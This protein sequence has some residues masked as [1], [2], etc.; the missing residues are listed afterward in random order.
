M[1]DTD[2]DL[3]IVGGG[4]AGITLA[5][6][7]E[8][9]GLRIALLESGGQD[10]DEATQDLNEGTLLGNSVYE[11]SGSRL[12][13]L[14]GTSNHWGG[15]CTPLDRIDFDRGPPGF[16]GWPMG[17]DEMVPYW[18]RAHRYCEVGAYTYDPRALGPS[19]PDHWLF[20]EGDGLDTVVLRQ[21]TPT[22]WGEA[23]GDRLAASGSIHVWLWTNA[24]G[25]STIPGR[26]RET[27]ATATLDGVMRTF[28][29]RAVVLAAGAIEGTRLLMWSNAG[30]GTQAGDSGGL[31]GRCYMDHIAGG[32]GFLHFER[33][34]SDKVYWAPPDAYSDGGT[35][36]FFA[37]RL[38]EA[39]LMETG[40]PNAIYHLL[41]LSTDA[42][43]RR[44]AM[45]ADQAFSSVRDLVKFAIGRDVGARFDPGTA[46]CAAVRN[47][48]E[49]VVDRADRLIN[50]QGV[51]SALLRFEAEERPGRQSHI[52]L[53][54]TARDALG[55]PR[56]VL[57]WSPATDDIEAVRRGAVEIGRMAG[58]LGL[59]RVELEDKSGEEYGVGTAWHQLG[60][61][62]MA[63]SPTAGV[64]DA[65]GRIHGAGELYVASGALFPTGGR[66]NPTLTITALSLRLADYLTERLAA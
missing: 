40:L 37:L 9:T 2:Y 7:L 28:S 61:M 39:A 21:S 24:T 27:V 11:L 34:Q 18:R 23:Y 8:A 49:F 20:D 36:L 31:L 42:E 1:P 5:L 57:T 53:D 15:Q 62:R 4:P 55:I 33:P 14:G 64:T 60:T 16:S 25:V 29:A 17:Y 10:Y 3:V 44:R 45:R 48:D 43:I 47:A 46:W 65:N 54:T 66:A 56:P 35:D 30:N 41:P 22:R 6:E 63:D 51:T 59:G 13:Y 50:G 26:P 38:S 12:R 19:E 52:T 32:A 58:A